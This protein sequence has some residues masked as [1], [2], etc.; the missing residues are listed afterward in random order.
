MNVTIDILSV[1]TT[2]LLRM[3]SIIHR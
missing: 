2:K 3:R 1:S